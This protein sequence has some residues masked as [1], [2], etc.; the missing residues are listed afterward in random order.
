A[1]VAAQTYDRRE[2]LL[3]DDGAPGVTDADV[4][5]WRSV[6]AVTLIRSEHRG[7]G[8]ARNLAL[9]AASGA[10]VAYLD[11]DNGWHPTYLARVVEALASR[12]DAGWTV[13]S[14]LVVHPGRMPAVRDDRHDP[15]TLA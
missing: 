11:V 12:P 7:V 8:A 3:V 10:I 6:P 1:E 4:A 5:R 2:M 13:A 14:Q 9:A 15:A